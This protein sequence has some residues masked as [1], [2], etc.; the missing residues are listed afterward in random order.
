MHFDD[1][2]IKCLKTIKNKV[3]S[4]KEIKVV[5]DIPFESSVLEKFKQLGNEI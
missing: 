5:Q 1:G 2:K 3:Y 4:S